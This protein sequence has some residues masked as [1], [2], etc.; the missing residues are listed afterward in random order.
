MSIHAVKENFTWGVEIL[1]RDKTYLA[2][3]QNINLRRWNL[4]ISNELTLEEN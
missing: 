3:Y 4:Y 2:F 1:V